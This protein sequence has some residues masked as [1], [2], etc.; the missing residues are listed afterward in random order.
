MYENQTT[1]RI[2]QITN[3]FLLEVCAN[4]KKEEEADEEDKC[5]CI[6]SGME[7]GEKE[8][9]CKD[10]ADL[11]AKIKAIV[12]LLTTEITSEDAFDAAFKVLADK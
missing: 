11:A 8:V 9:F 3:G 4:W 2:K 1:L 12:P 5:C 7:Y 6:G 10:A